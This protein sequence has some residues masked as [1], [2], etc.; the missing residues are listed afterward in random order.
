MISGS[1]CTY[2]FD[3]DKKETKKSCKQFLSLDLSILRIK[4][5][6]NESFLYSDDICTFKSGKYDIDEKI[7]T[8]SEFQ[9]FAS[10]FD[11]ELSSLTEVN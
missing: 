4:Q 8:D 2:L 7:F 6:V 9:H 1:T 11:Q 10:N 3:E 5:S